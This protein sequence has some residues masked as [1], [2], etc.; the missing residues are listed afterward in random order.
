MCDKI[1]QHWNLDSNK[2]NLR[3]RGKNIK[4]FLAFHKP[5]VPGLPLVEEPGNPC[6]ERLSVMPHLALSCQPKKGEGAKRNVRLN[7]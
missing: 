6:R 7:V 4:H 2:S 5:R 3:Q 1:T